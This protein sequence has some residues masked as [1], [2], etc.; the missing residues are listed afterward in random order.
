MVRSDLPYFYL[1]YFQDLIN[2][3]K[4]KGAVKEHVASFYAMELMKI[5]ESIHECGII[6]GDVKPDNLLLIGNNIR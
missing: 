4:A 6:H 2:Y 3:Y 1:L 5:L